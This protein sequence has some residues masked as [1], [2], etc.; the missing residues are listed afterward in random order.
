VPALSRCR[1]SCCCAWQPQFT[2][3]CRLRRHHFDLVLLRLGLDS[4]FNFLGSDDAEAGAGVAKAARCHTY[5]Y[6]SKSSRYQLKRISFCEGWIGLSEAASDVIF[7]LFFARVCEDFYRGAEFDQ[8]AEIK[9]RS[10]IGNASGLLHVVS[11]NHN[12][13]LRL[14]RLD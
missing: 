10:E 7:G 3:W 2:I 9:E 14:E 6:L 12:C 11:D 4:L 5:S 8:F 1:S 13:V